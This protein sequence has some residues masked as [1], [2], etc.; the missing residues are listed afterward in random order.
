MPASAVPLHGDLI[1]VVHLL[2]DHRENLLREH[3]CELVAI[4]RVIDATS[5]ALLV[6][7]AAAIRI[8]GAAP[9]LF[10][11]RRRR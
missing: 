9:V 6:E 4:H 2:A 1:G 10:L 5:V 8:L 3:L 7:D 11:E